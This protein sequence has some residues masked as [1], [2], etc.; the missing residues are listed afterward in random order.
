MIW[1]VTSLIAATVPLVL[2]V[3]RYVPRRG[4]RFWISWTFALVAWSGIVTHTLHE[5]HLDRLEWIAFGIV[6]ASVGCLVAI[7]LAVKRLPLAISYGSLAVT[8]SFLVVSWRSEWSGIGGA[9][10]GAVSM[11]AIAWTLSR[12]RTGIGRG[13]VHL[14]PLLGLAVG[15]FDP[16]SVLIAWFFTLLVGGLV[17]AI[18]LGSRRVTRRSTIPYGPF[19]ALGAAV[20]IS[21]VS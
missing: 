15:W 18:L 19:L 6:A 13:D 20:A 8:I 17:S 16:W 12:V 21:L 7:D 3:D 4:G 1:F 2:A 5:R 11:F 10:I 9:A 14:S